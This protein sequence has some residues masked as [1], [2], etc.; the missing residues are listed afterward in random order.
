MTIAALDAG[1]HVLC[2]ARMAMDLQQ[3][4][5]MLEASKRHPELTAQVVPSPMTL[6]YDKTIRRLVDDGSIGQIVAIDVRGV[7]SKFPDFEAP[8][9]WREDRELSGNNIMMMGIFYEAVSWY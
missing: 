9:H 8:I 4:R 2:E 5:D 1:K 7:G 6:K 3:A